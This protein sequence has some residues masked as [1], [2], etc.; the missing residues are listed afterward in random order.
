MQTLI[1]KK[2]ESDN[3]RR[4]KD[5]LKA[6]FAKNLRC[7]WSLDANQWNLDNPDYKVYEGDRTHI[8]ICF[9]RDS[10]ALN[11]STEVDLPRWNVS[12][13]FV[14]YLQNLIETDSLVIF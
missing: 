7:L 6:K 2:L 14:F 12:S 8:L 4:V 3:F 5:L 1:I 10:Y 11:L 13:F 9:Y